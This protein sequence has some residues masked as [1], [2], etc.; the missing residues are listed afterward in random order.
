MYLEE[1]CGHCFVFTEP[2]L[3]SL[4]YKVNIIGQSI[5]TAKHAL[6]NQDCIHWLYACT[7]NGKQKKWNKSMPSAFL[8]KLYWALVLKV[9]EEKEFRQLWWLWVGGCDIY[10]V[11]ISWV[12]HSHPLSPLT[13]KDTDIPMPKKI[14]CRL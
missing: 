6:E 11:Q 8:L 14:S 3:L 7:K 4:K 5:V 9:T 12:S 1:T 2:W 13:W 10:T